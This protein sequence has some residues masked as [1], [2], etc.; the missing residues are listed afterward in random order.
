VN[1]PVT[2]LWGAPTSSVDWCEANYEHTKYVCEF[3]N[4]LSS[5]AMVLAGGLGAWLHR[6]TLE[7]RFL[8][9]FSCLTLVGLGSIAFHATLR[10]EFQMLDELPMLYTALIMIFIVVENERERRFGPWL[11]AALIAHGALLTSLAAFTRGTLQFYLFQFSFGSMEI[12]VLYRVYVI[13]RSSASALLRKLFRVGTIS[14]GLAI[15]CWFVDLKGCRVVGAVFPAHGFPNPQLHAW[16]HIL[17]SIGLYV[18]TLM[19][20]YHRLT[21]LAAGPSLRFALGVPHLAAD[22]LRGQRTAIQNGHR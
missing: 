10:F 13:Y 11:S 14:Y 17:V 4:T 16:W 9:A 19:L 5:A 15:L 8:W 7:R 20:A 3:Y 22:P 21:V 6:R 12:F 18:L 1:L 2:G